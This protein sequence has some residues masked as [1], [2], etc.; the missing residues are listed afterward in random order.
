MKLWILSAIFYSVVPLVTDHF[1]A[2]IERRKWLQRYGLR[3]LLRGSLGNPKLILYSTKQTNK[4]P[5][6]GKS[7]GKYMK[8]KNHINKYTDIV[9][10]AEVN[11]LQSLPHYTLQLSLRYPAENK[12]QRN[13]DCSKRNKT[14]VFL[15]YYSSNFKTDAVLYTALSSPG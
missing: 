13:T 15:I 11:G 14:H 6:R 9:L 4:K 12:R 5:V 7:K 2:S 1:L 10:V 3:V 8:M